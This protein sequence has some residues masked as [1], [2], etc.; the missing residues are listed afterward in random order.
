MSKGERE[1]GSRRK[2]GHKG[3]KGVIANIE[4]MSRS[5]ALSVGEIAKAEDT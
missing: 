4:Q 5:H 2:R 1:K 3:E